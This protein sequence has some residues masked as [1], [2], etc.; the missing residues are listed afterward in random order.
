MAIIKKSQ[1]YR[2]IEKKKH[3]STEAQAVWKEG[4]E[5]KVTEYGEKELG[6]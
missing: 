6:E 1:Q 4:E 3:K 5:Q 2:S